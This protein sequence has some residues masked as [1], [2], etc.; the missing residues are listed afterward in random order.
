MAPHVVLPRVRCQINH[1]SLGVHIKNNLSILLA[2]IA[3]FSLRS[4]KLGGE[5]FTS[6]GRL[7]TE[8][9]ERTPSAAAH[10][11]NAADPIPRQAPT[12]LPASH[13]HPDGA[14]AAARGSARTL[15]WSPPRGERG[16]RPCGA[17]PSRWTRRAEGPPRRG[18]RAGVGGAGRG[19]GR[20]GGCPSPGGGR[21][22]LGF[23]HDVGGGARPGRRELPLPLLQ[24]APGRGEDAAGG[25]GGAAQRR[26]RGSARQE[27][28]LAP[29]A[30]LPAEALLVEEG[31]ARRRPLQRGAGGGEGGA[32]GRRGAPRT[33]A[34]ARGAAGG[35]RPRRPARALAVLPA[36]ADDGRV[37]AARLAEPPL[38][39][40]LGGGGG[41]GGRGGAGEDAAQQALRRHR[42]GR[43]PGHGG[44]DR[45]SWALAAAASGPRRGG[46]EQ[47]GSRGVPRPRAQ[48]PA[49]RPD[50]GIEGLMA[51]SGAAPG[52]PPPRSLCWEGEGGIGGKKK[53]TREKGREGGS[54][55]AFISTRRRLP[56]SLPSR[57]RCARESLAAHPPRQ[58]AGRQSSPA[59]PRRGESPSRCRP[60]PDASAGRPRRG[61][62]S[63]QPRRAARAPGLR[64]PGAVPGGPDEA[65]RSRW[66]CAVPF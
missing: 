14:A 26:G 22:Y 42:G 53:V 51:A 29:G 50:G 45:G 37:E 31:A 40:A 32:G 52:L 27:G 63:R 56:E 20:R 13:D 4:V 44:D 23:P 66:H 55:G 2:A 62:G 59:S 16:R 34:L 48:P 47:R 39:K 7:H 41:G 6:P 33:A 15:P 54:S 1:S 10:L 18:E 49:A 24:P 28:Q 5:G 30:P 57:P 46:A 17:A 38:G 58:V 25:A 9:I 8:P 12:P 21:T 36:A 61:Y 43:C 3:Y 19:R 11:T 60:H 64:L 65:L 35:P